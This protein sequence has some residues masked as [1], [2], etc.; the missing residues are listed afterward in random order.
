M[1]PGLDEYRRRR[2]FGKTPEPAAGAGRPSGGRP[3]FVV[4]RHDA[5]ALHFDLRLEIEGVLASWAIPK[6][7]PLRT[8]VKRLAMRT[9]DHP[10]EYL[11]FS[12]VIP[13]GQYG[14]GRMTIWD[15]GTFDLVGRT[16]GG[17]W[18]VAR[19]S[20]SDRFLNEYWGRWDGEMTWLDVLVDDFAP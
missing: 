19:S 6:G 20:D 18:W 16:D 4:Q 17:D 3:R 14:A 1:S 12:G 8:G 13:D 5:R 2:D 15:R 10:L 7:L 9:E 11:D